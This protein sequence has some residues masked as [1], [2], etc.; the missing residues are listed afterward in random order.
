MTCSFWEEIISSS[1]EVFKNFES[2]MEVGIRT[3]GNAT[4]ETAESD[5]IEKQNVDS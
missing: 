4:W 2:D 1:N 3:L 5:F